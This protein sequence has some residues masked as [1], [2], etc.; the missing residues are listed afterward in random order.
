MRTPET[1]EEFSHTV[2][3]FL[4]FEQPVPAADLK[5]CQVLSDIS[6]D[7]FSCFSELNRLILIQNIC[8]CS[9]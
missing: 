7:L 6:S 1:E 4:L 9:R 2:R 5:H 8:Y 3:Y